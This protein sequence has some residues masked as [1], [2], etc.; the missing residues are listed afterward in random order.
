M[1]LRE[2]RWAVRHCFSTVQP[3][4]LDFKFMNGITVN[5]F[6]Y[7]NITEAKF[8]QFGLDRM[9]MMIIRN[10]KYLGLTIIKPIFTNR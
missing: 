5:P 8:S 7:I 2:I 10:F 1:L 3:N 9:M 6:V 4:L